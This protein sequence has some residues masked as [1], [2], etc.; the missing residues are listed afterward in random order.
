[1]ADDRRGPMPEHG[2]TISSPCEPECSG[3]LKIVSVGMWQVVTCLNSVVFS[4]NTQNGTNT[5]LLVPI[6]QVSSENVHTY[7]SLQEL[8][9]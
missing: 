9:L 3:E 6:L 5:K 7:K 2:Y 4:S 1:M 8:T